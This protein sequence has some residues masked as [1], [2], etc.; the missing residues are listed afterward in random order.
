MLK[1][2]KFFQHYYETY[3]LEHIAEKTQ[4][5][6]NDDLS[7]LQKVVNEIADEIYKASDTIEFARQEGRSHSHNHN[8]NR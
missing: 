2:L 7:E 5:I 8:I 3:P 6:Y 1:W 4:V